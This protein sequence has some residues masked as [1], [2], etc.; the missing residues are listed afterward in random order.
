MEAV[1]LAVRSAF[2]VSIRIYGE[3]EGASI[4]SR[5]TGKRTREAPSERAL[6]GRPTVVLPAISSARDYPLWLAS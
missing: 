4:L 3:D 1:I 6:G 2:V 5:G